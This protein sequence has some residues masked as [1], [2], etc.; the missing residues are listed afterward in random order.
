MKNN[1]LS[2]ILTFITLT[3]GLGIVQS[4][5]T[6]A[7]STTF[8]CGV[9]EGKP[10]TVAATPRGNIPII[11]WVSNKFTGAGYNPQRRCEE[12]S[13]RFQKLYDQGALT[14]ITAG[15][16]NRQPVICA[17]GSAGGLCNSDNLLYTL[18]RGQDAARTIQRL[19]EIRGGA[20]GPLRE[21]TT[22]ININNTESVNVNELLN[23]G[24]VDPNASVGQNITNT[25]PVEETP[26]NTPNTPTKPN[27]GG[28]LW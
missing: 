21:D 22:G 25:R 6:Y 12:V 8:V 23:N 26:N 2:T 10:A 9:S 15:Y 17:T 19:N 18:K 1:T 27:N 14:F 11:L 5:P 20:S 4:Q 16:L 7:Q 3:M 28:G 24:K 13:P